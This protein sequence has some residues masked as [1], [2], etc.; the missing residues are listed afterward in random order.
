MAIQQNETQY[1]E[2][3]TRGLFDNGNYTKSE[4]AITD[5][6]EKNNILSEDIINL[7]REWESQSVRL[8]EVIE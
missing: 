4:K 1:H 5:L 3:D 8:C 6:L 7:K 2:E